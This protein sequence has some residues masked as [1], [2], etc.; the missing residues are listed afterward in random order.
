[1][2]ETP[3]W[4]Y[5]VD[6]DPSMREALSSLT[7][8]RGW[9]VKTFESAQ[10][11]LA[12]PRPPG[13][14]CL[15]LDIQLPGLTG[16][17][18]QQRLGRTRDAIPI[19]YITG[20]ADVATAV[21]AIK[22]GAVEFLTKPFDHQALL[23]AIE[24]CL[25]RGSIPRAR[26]DDSHPARH[27]LAFD[28]F[29]LD[30]GEQ[31]LWRC[32]EGRMERILPNPKAFSVLQYLVERAGRLVTED[33]LLQAVWP[34]VYVQPDVVKSQLYEIRKA[35]G[36]SHKA[37]RFI[38]TLHRRGYR[39]IAAVRNATAPDRLS[40]SEASAQQDLPG[41]GPAL[42]VLR[43]RMRLALG[44]QR[45]V[46]FVHGDIGIGKTALVDE[47]RRLAAIESPGLRVAYGHCV[48]AGGEMETYYPM[49]EA[50]ESLCRESSQ[51]VDVVAA[52][53]PS[54]LVQF[55]ALLTDEHRRTLQQ[56]IMGATRER[57]L[58][59]IAQTLETISVET[60]L[61]VVLEDLQWADGPTLDLIS[62]LAR[63]RTPAQ[64]MLVGT[65]RPMDVAA[66]AHPYRLLTHDLLARGLCRL[67]D[68]EPLT[69]AD[70]AAYLPA[71]S[72]EHAQREAVARFL[73]RMSGGNPLFLR[74]V[75][76]HLS[77]LQIAYR[78][79]SGWQFKTPLPEQDPPVPQSIR[80]MIESQLQLLA[81]QDRRALEAASLVGA[82]F[83]VADAARAGGSEI[84]ELEAALENLARYKRMVRR[85]SPHFADGGE[86]YYEFTNSLYRDVL[87][88]Q[89]TRGLR[90]RRAET[91]RAPA[92][93]QTMV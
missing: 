81:P 88:G 80:V 2:R 7:R 26:P 86:A 82:V 36:D 14:S 78:T 71:G 43:E 12:H 16:L 17:E 47:F 22:A 70:I 31:C 28:P 30:V 44:G 85:T 66:S 74:A 52:H 68:L 19:I 57:M 1:M 20:K 87:C 67:I 84:E 39:F 21:R 90:A 61:L 49:L 37:P 58:R 92:P 13:P 23:A 9:R 59:E 65:S 73:H 91:R 3:G 5:I 54:W 63:R 40:D 75:L 62:A 93:S 35:L 83:G 18:L 60:P 77:E 89:P 79:S 15:V 33:E 72:T 11:F 45:Q 53:A 55:P 51:I 32:S 27:V 25:A 64:L 4:V 46:A 42:A 10:T 8:S 76:D 38:E 50:L 41:R 6:D 48:Q 56:E 29:L 24:H 34:T 69:P